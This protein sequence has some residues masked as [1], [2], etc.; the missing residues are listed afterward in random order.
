M[1]YCY[2][3]QYVSFERISSIVDGGLI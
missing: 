2:Y 1:N 3:E